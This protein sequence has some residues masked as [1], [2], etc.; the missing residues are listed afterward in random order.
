MEHWEKQE[1]D[2]QLVAARRFFLRGYSP[3]LAHAELK[4]IYAPFNVSR[5]M[6]ELWFRDFWATREKSNAANGA[7]W[8]FLEASPE[9][10]Q[11]VLETVRIAVER[12]WG[13]RLT[14]GF[15]RCIVH[16][17]KSCPDLPPCLAYQLAELIEVLPFPDDV[18]FWGEVWDSVIAR[19]C[20]YRPWTGREAWERY[21]RA[22]RADGAKRILDVSHSDDSCIISWFP[23][24]IGD[25]ARG[26]RHAGKKQGSQ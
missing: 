13:Y 1:I 17:R 20:V 18:R 7:L 6:I 25:R 5:N 21:E 26:Q 15:A 22:A 9:E 24:P 16:L 2:G 3:E 8:N 19:F 23:F 10:A 12:G 11:L 14:N 4:A